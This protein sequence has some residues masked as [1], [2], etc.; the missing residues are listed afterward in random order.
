M[1]RKATINSFEQLKEQDKRL[2]FNKKTEF[3]Q[4]F[5]K[6][7]KSRRSSRSKTTP[8]T[9]TE[10]GSIPEGNTLLDPL[11]HLYEPLSAATSKADSGILSG[12]DADRDSLHSD[13]LRSLEMEVPEDEPT[14]QSVS[15]RL[16][17]FKQLEEQARAPEKEKPKSRS[18][19][20]KR[21]IE[22]KKRERSRT[23]P[24][25]EDEVKTASEFADTDKQKSGTDKKLSESKTPSK[26]G[27]SDSEDELSRSVQG[28]RWCLLPCGRVT[29]VVPLC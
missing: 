18:I 13:S 6:E 21:M 26:D 9:A 16:S 25:T 5:R 11:L 20:A 28:Q 15:A 1:R 17:I 2:M 22:K 7:K 24:I 19:G 27:S 4:P 23:Q 3:P 29:P 14:R 8:I 10:L 12:S